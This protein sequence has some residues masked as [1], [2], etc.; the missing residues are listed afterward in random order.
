MAFR[1]FD[2]YEDIEK[3]LL[4][5]KLIDITSSRSGGSGGSHSADISRTPQIRIRDLF[6][7][8]QSAAAFSINA[9]PV[10]RMI[11]EWMKSKIDFQTWDNK[12]ARDQIFSS[13]DLNGIPGKF[14]I[15]GIDNDLVGRGGV[16]LLIKAFY[17]TCRDY[18]DHIN[19]DKCN[20]TVADVNRHIWKQKIPFLIEYYRQAFAV[21]PFLGYVDAYKAL[22]LSRSFQTL[23]QHQVMSGSWLEVNLE[24]FHHCVKLAA[25]GASDDQINEIRHEMTGV[26]P[27]LDSS[28]LRDIYGGHWRMYEGWLSKGY[29][30]LGDL[31]AQNLKARYT[32]PTDVHGAIPQT[33]TLVDICVRQYGYWK[34]APSSSCFSGSSRVRMASGETEAMCDIKPGDSILSDPLSTEE[35]RRYRTVAFVG[36][37]RLGKRCLYEL[38]RF[39]DIRF[40]STHPILLAPSRDDDTSNYPILHF[41]DRVFAMSLNP[42]WQSFCTSDLDQRDLIVHE[43]TTD[44]DSE[45]VYDL[46]LEPLSLTYALTSTGPLPTFVMVGANGLEL[47]VISEAPLVEWFPLEM[48]FMGNVVSAISSKTQDI[49]QVLEVL[50]S[51]SSSLQSI[52]RGLAATSISE[53]NAHATTTMSLDSLLR[54][55]NH[56][57]AQK[58]VDLL[59][60]LIIK[61]G[62]TVGKVISSGW[63]NMS[64]S[65]HADNEFVDVLFL[66]VLHRLE[67]AHLFRRLPISSSWTLYVQRDNELK[68]Q[69]QLAGRVQGEETLILHQDILLQHEKENR[70]TAGMTGPEAPQWI[71]IELSDEANGIVWQGR[72]PL[73]YG[74]QSMIS[75]GDL[76][77]GD[78]GSH[79]VVEVE[80]CS[81]SSVSL[82]NRPSWS[83]PD[84]KSYA[85]S[86]GYAFGLKLAD[87]SITA[88]TA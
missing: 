31:G 48:I 76:R 42:T 73:E 38:K 9:H 33:K 47:T 88:R 58:V 71:E 70:N 61:I 69:Y 60:K 56:E 32:I 36:K 74:V 10:I 57:G 86:L 78:I 80:L 79:A 24:M 41:V 81:V 65:S 28:A 63:I 40:T 52:L 68:Q 2:G 11:V 64:S 85:A 23:K 35:T 82:A 45:V 54:T 3:E 16:A 18:D 27:R 83:M 84:Q 44:H 15:E 29:L 53:S 62:R 13:I 8:T 59:E 37:P 46:I 43:S 87:G 67:D 51:D 25:C 1:T 6:K 72:G 75:A 49:S 34:A 26:E 5:Q 19:M 66:H 17:N 20:Q 55:S 12:R 39:P 77:A 21:G 4:E 30:D 22:L 50:D 14:S 7:T